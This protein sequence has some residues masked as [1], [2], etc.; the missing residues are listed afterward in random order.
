MPDNYESYQSGASLIILELNE[1]IRIIERDQYTNEKEENKQKRWL[2]FL[3]YWLSVLFYNLKD[4]PC[5]INNLNKC[6]DYADSLIEKKSKRIVS[7]GFL[8]FIFSILEVLCRFIDNK[9]S[10]TKGKRKNKDKKE[11][12]ILDCVEK[13]KYL[14]E[15]IWKV[16][17]RPSVWKYWFNSPK[18][19]SKKSKR[20]FG[21]VL[22]FL[23]L[24][25]FSIFAGHFLLFWNIADSIKTDLLISSAVMLLLFIF[26]PILT[27]FKSPVME[28]EFLS[29]AELDIASVEMESMLATLEAEESESVD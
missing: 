19:L 9:S 1:L 7:K 23:L 25:H 14:L 28:M 24:Y 16:N 29:P 21:V 8:N 27:S 18:Y 10:I 2:I 17:I 3:F 15:H 13:A 22:S 5:A 4:Y 11:D 6:M 26:A 12:F 20:A